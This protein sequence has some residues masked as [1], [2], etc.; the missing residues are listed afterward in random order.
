MNKL[1]SLTPQDLYNAY[2]AKGKLIS[3]V[4]FKVLFEPKTELIFFCNPTL[5]SKMGEIK[6]IMN[7]YL[8]N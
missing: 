6:K 4:N 3:D 5:S 7:H 8:S 1:D 2:N